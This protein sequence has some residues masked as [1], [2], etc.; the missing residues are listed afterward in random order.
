MLEVL[1][2]YIQLKVCFN[3]EGCY[4]PSIQTRWMRQLL[5]GCSF[6]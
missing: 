1:N 3:F 6:G 2:K 5:L 4:H